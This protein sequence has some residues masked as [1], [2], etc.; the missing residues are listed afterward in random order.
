MASHASNDTAKPHNHVGQHRAKEQ[1][2]PTSGQ[3]R[4]TR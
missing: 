3:H 4:R 1:S 2:K